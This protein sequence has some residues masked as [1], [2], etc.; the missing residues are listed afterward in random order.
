MSSKKPWAD[1]PFKLI[2]ST[3]AGTKKGVK[4]AG[5]NRMAEEM[6]IIHNLILRI[7]NTVYLQCINV[8]KSPNDVQDF[9]SYAIEWSK[10]VEEHHE[11]EET[12]VFPEI[13]QLAG[14]PGLMRAN[15]AQHEAFHD[16]LHAYMG[17]LDKVQKGEE[18]YSGEKLKGIIDSFMPVLREHLSDEIDS[19]L[20]LNE[21]D[22][23]W[24]EWYEKLMKKLLGRM[25]DAKLKTTTIPLLLTNRD[26]TFEEGVHAWWPPVPWIAFL[27][28]RWLYIPAHKNWWRFSSCD[29]RGAPR[30]LP[31]A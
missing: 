28:M 31:F 27:M 1:G 6:T 23:N 4:T 13:E 3:R 2:S 11:T 20:R 15:V 10:M 9:V 12:D 22:R 16:G 26:T 21:Y 7:I 5:V 29:D 19:L 25:G 30:E 14:V 18:A 17:Y 8:E 24:D